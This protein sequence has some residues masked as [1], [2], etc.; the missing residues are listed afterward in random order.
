MRRERSVRVLLLLVLV[1]VVIGAGPA[2]CGSGVPSFGPGKPT[3]VA[4]TTYLADITH[5]VAGSRVEVKSLIPEGADS[6]SFEPTPR[7]A[8]LLAEGRLVIVD[9]LGLTPLVDGL[10]E[11]SAHQ[12]QLVIEAASGLAGLPADQSAGSDE[13]QAQSPPTGGTDPHFWLDPVM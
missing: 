5:N 11:G 2:S 8:R 13:G 4:V 1:A 9:I 12:D 7:D 3:V 10:I 6:H